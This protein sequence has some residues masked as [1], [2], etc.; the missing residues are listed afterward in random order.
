MNSK[1]TRRGTKKRAKRPQ[2]AAMP[3]SRYGSHAGRGFRYQDA[4]AVWL[5]VMIWS[6]RREAARVVPEGGD[7]IELRGDKT[8]FLQV[9][10]RREHLG[11]YGVGETTS[12][13]CALWDRHDTAILQPNG[14][15]LILER[16]VAG[17]GQQVCDNYTIPIAD[18]VLKSLS[19]KKG[20]SEL[21]PKTKLLV[22]RSPHEDVVDMI[23]QRTGCQPIAAQLCHAELL[24]RIGAM[25]DQNGKLDPK[26][27]L[28]LS[29]SDTEAAITDVLSAIDVD[30]LEQAILEG[31][32]EPVDFVTPIHDPNFYLGINV[33]PGHL[34]AG[35]VVERPSGRAQISNAIETQRA[36]LVVGPSG[37]GKSA[38]MWE[39]AY[40]LRHVIRWFRINRVESSDLPSIRQLVRGLRVSESSPVGLVMDDVGVRGSGGWDQLVRQFT[41]IPGVVILGSIREEDIFLIEERSG[42]VEV[43]AQPDDE[44]AERLWSELRGTGRTSW[45][46]WLEPWNLSGRLLLEYVHTLSRGRRM[47]AVL[48]D[49][50][51]ARSRDPGRAV[52]LVV[53]QIG[54]CAGMAGAQI[55]IRRLTNATGQGEA[56]VN[57]ALH[58]LVE[59]HLVHMPT[60]GLLE[61]LHQLRS[62][63]LFRLTHRMPPPNPRETFSRT[64]L[65][66]PA[67]ELEAL[68]A[69]AMIRH[70]LDVSDLIKALAH[71]LEMEQDPG[72]LA[73]ALRGLGTGFVSSGVDRWLETQE[74]RVLP[75]TQITTAALFGISGTEMPEL[76]QLE[77][78][79]AA[80]RRLAEIKGE[81]A[82]DPRLKL[83]AALLPSAIAPMV[84]SARLSDLE[85]ILAALVGSALPEEVR[86]SLVAL[87]PDLLGGELEIVATLLGTV[88]VLD[89]DIGQ[90]WAKAAGQK[91]LLERISKEVPWAGNVTL[92]QEE[93][94]LTVNCD[95]WY[96]APSRQ[97]L[98][99]DDVVRICELLIAICPIADFAVSRAVGSNGELAGFSK[100][101]VA[102]KRIPRSGLPPASLPA[103][104]RRWQDMVAR[105][106]ATPSYSEYLARGAS[107]L[108]KLVPNL[109]RI[110][111]AHLRGRNA[112]TKLFEALNLLN[113]EA[114]EL[115]P[116]INSVRA[117]TGVGSEERKYFSTPLQDILFNSSVNT[118][119]RFSDLPEGAGAYISWLGSLIENVDTATRDE[120][121]QLIGNDPP[122]NLIRLRN[123]LDIL[124]MLAGEAHVRNAPPAHTWSRIG[125]KARAGNALRSISAIVGTAESGRA[126]KLRAELE[127]A[128]RESG[129]AAKF[130]LRRDQGGI[131]PWPPLEILATINAD[132]ITEAATKM[133]ASTV[134][135]RSL[136]DSTTC[137]TLIPVVSGFA[138][139]QF[140]K[141]GY[142]TMLPVTE[143]PDQWLDEIGI[144][145]LPTPRAA[146][147]GAV[148]GTATEIGSM[149]RKS[150]GESDRPVPEA[151]IKQELEAVY[152]RD[153][154]RLIKVLEEEPELA[155]I[156]ASFVRDIRDGNVD[157]SG[158]EQA[159]LGE[160]VSREL[161]EVGVMMVSIL[162]MDLGA[163][164][165]DKKVSR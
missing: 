94:G 37:A 78:V 74:V 156:A 3:Y 65:S 135:I 93:D 104:N 103:W 38:L 36:A 13:I 20:S 136:I 119:K 68:V 8:S 155:D 122:S 128:T 126:K 81:W 164:I 45:E 141:S 48:A 24:V 148:V 54:S 53:L 27:Y 138:L 154:R 102:S 142:Q 41:A 161:A 70:Q 98:P 115:T 44:L 32:C 120:P 33:E 163:T 144:P 28:G 139:E 25:A 75:R 146:V 117:A 52:E 49:Q 100:H 125:R 121:W 118:I 5:T 56:E 91:E 57:R 105:R 124:R 67:V 107:I 9:K 64:V 59:E 88:N 77:E 109:E 114:T 6:G 17:L 76:P 42:V 95:Y 153:R 60:P 16:G 26:N 7:D 140:A 159:I 101:P 19:S 89:R 123:L 72:A 83:M 43:R 35:L 158:Q 157:L 2:Q 165:S 71:R 110:F 130:H 143:I 50:V 1:R 12:H 47:E 112:P 46:G 111:E 82:D 31:V 90:I 55:D 18:D 14:L 58:R 87:K 66:V 21:L 39:A 160:E 99:H 108:N 84:A 69:E 34:A 79:N 97:P 85:Q 61:G 137:L 40:S 132:S 127:N 22:V 129:I 51:A 147:F 92:H 149:G 11:P 113:Q 29:P 116:P 145:I 4:I 96:V 30:A 150:F 80:G 106:I 151:T 152:E 162:E 131:L 63:E 23:V 62:Q 10:S 86:S 134:A 133:E 15:E 73:A